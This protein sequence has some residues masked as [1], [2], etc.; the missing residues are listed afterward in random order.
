MRV[1]VLY[2]AVDG[3]LA[4]LGRGWIESRSRS[5]LS[6]F[7]SSPMSSPLLNTGRV[8]GSSARFMS[9]DST[10]AS[11]CS[12]AAFQAVANSGSLALRS[13][14]EETPLP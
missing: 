14:D 5:P 10:V 9:A 13:Q 2:G 7:S 3:E 8:V 4:A 11:A 1:V 12:S 6:Y